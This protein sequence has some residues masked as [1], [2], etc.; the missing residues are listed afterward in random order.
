M[1]GKQVNKDPPVKVSTIEVIENKI[2]LSANQSDESIEKSKSVNQSVAEKED[3]KIATNVE[4]TISTI[5]PAEAA[6]TPIK[7]TTPTAATATPTKPMPKAVDTESA[8]EKD[9][10][11]TKHSSESTESSIVTPHYI[12]QSMNF[13]YIKRYNIC[14]WNRFSCKFRLFFFFFFSHTRCI[15]SMQFKSGNRRE[16]IKFTAMS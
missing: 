2:N 14:Y 12:Q 13:F 4:E 5:S 10:V 6:T 15:S 7:S 3:A 9:K 8:K 11:K 1:N 16:A